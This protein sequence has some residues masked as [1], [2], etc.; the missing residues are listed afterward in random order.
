MD[1]ISLFKSRISQ[2]FSNLLAI[3][4]KTGIGKSYL[5]LLLGECLDQNFSVDNVAFSIKE[6]L[7]L[8]SNAKNGDCLALDD[9]G[10]YYDARRF[11]E[12][13]HQLLGYALES[14]RFKQ[15]TICFTLPSLS[16]I[17]LNAR[18]LIDFL[19]LIKQRGYCSIKVRKFKSD[20]TDYWSPLQL[21]GFSFRH[22]SIPIPSKKLA[23]EYEAKK[24]QSLNHLY[25]KL[26]KE[27]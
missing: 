17:D 4:G 3:C 1:L 20:G 18:R 8:I 13:S 21:K 16:M 27:I 2:K 25:E 22:V 15:I 9:A 7:D 19:I 6:F 14:C 11:Q 5:A 26:V 24:R 12:K 10:I 23:N